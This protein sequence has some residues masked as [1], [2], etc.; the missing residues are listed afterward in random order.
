[1][2]C[3]HFQIM[4]FILDYIDKQKYLLLLIRSSLGLCPWEAGPLLTS[5]HLHLSHGLA[6]SHGK[7]KSSNRAA[8]IGAQKR[9]HYV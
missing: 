3:S 4:T 8:A 2:I 9:G 6:C 7:Q 1:M 5:V